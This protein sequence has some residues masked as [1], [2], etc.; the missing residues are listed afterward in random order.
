MQP[1]NLPKV[2]TS[3]APLP[4]L[5]WMDAEPLVVR[6]GGAARKYV[7]KHTTRTTKAIIEAIDHKLDITTLEPISDVQSLAMN[8]IGAVRVK[9]R[10]PLIVD[11]Y[12]VNRATGGFIVIDELTNHTVGAGMILPEKA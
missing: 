5:C 9:V 10:D 8:D 4:M 1:S 7:I 11:A 12:D 6:A 2:K 3:L